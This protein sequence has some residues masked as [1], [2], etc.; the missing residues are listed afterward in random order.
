MNLCEAGRKAEHLAAVYLRARG[1]REV[2]P[3]LALGLSF[4]P[5]FNWIWTGWTMKKLAL[6]AAGGEGAA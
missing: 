2:S 1:Y 6:F 4:I 5:L 3:G